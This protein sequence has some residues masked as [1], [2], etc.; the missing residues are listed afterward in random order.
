MKIVSL[1]Y[2][3]GKWI[4]QE[5]I[6]EKEQKIIIANVMKKAG[7]SVGAEVQTDLKRRRAGNKKLPAV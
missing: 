3:N 6:S 4:E 2:I 1:L 7:M 5:K